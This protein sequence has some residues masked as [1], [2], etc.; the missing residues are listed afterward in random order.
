MCSIFGSFDKNKV[1]ELIK[2]NEYR[3]TFSYSLT[4]LPTNGSA[5]VM[6]KGFGKIPDDILD[7]C[8]DGYFL[9]HCQAPTNGLVQDYNRIHP[10]VFKPHN[11]DYNMYLLHNGIIKPP[12]VDAINKQLNTNYQ[13]DTQAFAESINQI[14]LIPTL[15]SVE[16]SFACVMFNHIGDW[17]K[18]FRN[19]VAPLFVDDDL[20]ISS[21]LFNGNNARIIQP[22]IIYHIDL[23]E[24]EIVP[25][26]CFNNQH[27]PFF[28]LN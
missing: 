26:H 7:M 18:M 28:F 3:G 27:K 10:C 2:L 15:N 9:G 11:S 14:G 12:Y 5:N 6:V 8:N 21:T 20:N 24:R 4:F 13:W 16:G 25:Q 19:T 17:F 22:N 1:K 23:P